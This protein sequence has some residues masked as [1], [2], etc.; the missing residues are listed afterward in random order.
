MSY[1]CYQLKIESAF[2]RN[3]YRIMEIS[4]DRTFAELSDCILDAFEFDKD[5]LYMFSLNRK[6]YDPNGIYHPM[7]KQGK[8]ADRVRLQDVNPVVKNKYL[9]LYDFG[10]D[11]MFYI[12]VMKVSETDLKIPAK[13]TF[14]QGEL[15]QYP[16]WDEDWEN[17]EDWDGEEDSYDEEACDEDVFAASDDLAITPVYE[18]DAVVKEKLMSIPAI[19]QNMW[20][21]L[22]KEDLP[23]AGDEEIELLYRLEKAGLVEVDE[24]ETHLF[25]RVNRGKADYKEYGIWDNLQKRYDLEHVIV[26][27]VGI[28]GVVEQDMLY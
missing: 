25:L 26:A 13:I 6:A 12:T 5:H 28:Y 22:V 4:G 21:R 17:E 8:R 2:N 23:M 10:D 14:R 3:I 19:L 18:D 20:I 24:S 16:N 7:G 1:L 15:C 27:L 9:Y 11:W